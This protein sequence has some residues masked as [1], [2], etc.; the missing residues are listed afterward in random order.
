MS[1]IHENTVNEG[2]ERTSAASVTEA[3]TASFRKLRHAALAAALL[4]IAGSLAGLLPRWRQSAALETETRDLAIQT[5]AVISPAPGQPSAGLLLPAEIKPFIEAPI[6]ARASGYLKRWYADLGAQVKAGDLLAEIDSP[7]LNQELAQAQAVL[8]QTEAALALSKTTA[9]RWAE[10]LKTASVSE[11]EAAERD[12]DYKL[13]LANVQA[14]RANVARLEELQR[15]EKITAP[16]EG[17]IVARNTDVG[18]LITTGTVNSKELFRLAQTRT[19]RVFVRV[20]QAATPGLAPGQPAELT[21][22]ELP[23]HLFQA[24][25]VRTSGAMTP[26]SRTLLTEL[27]VDNPR[28][29]ILP[30][31]FAQVRLSGGGAQASMTLPANTLLFRPEGPQ[32]GV[33]TGQGT[34]ELRTVQLGRDFGPSVEILGG[35]TTN[36]A[37]ILN[38]P[39]SLISG[40]QVRVA[41][42]SQPAS[43]NQK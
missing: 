1:Q 31:T 35:V 40:I 42:N 43:S 33:V 20:P 36:D 14:A 21:V 39:D 2:R 11:Q 30:G 38:P 5:V 29:Q 28:Q 12:A 19:L 18:Q 16:F 6:Y 15:F 8:A 34:V 41:A 26:D 9:E 37:V 25:V 7:E 13:K 10:L 4:V 27:E 22:P 32:V 17:I 24:T 3:A 23:G